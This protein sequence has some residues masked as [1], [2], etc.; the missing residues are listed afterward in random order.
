MILVTPQRFRFLRKL[1]LIILIIY[2]LAGSSLSVEVQSSSNLQP[3]THNRLITKAQFIST[4][5][6]WIISGNRLLL[7]VDGANTFTDITP[8]NFGSKPLKAVKFINQVYGLV[9]SVATNPDGAGQ[10]Q[11]A[12]TAD[13]GKNWN[14]YP[15]GQPSG[16]YA[17]A[18]AGNGWFSFTDPKNGW[19]LVQL[20]SS[21]NF[22]LGVLYNTN[23]GGITWQKLPA[24][25]IADKFNFASATNGWLAGGTSGN[26]LYVTRDA[27]ISWQAVKISAPPGAVD[28][29]L[30]L[31]IPIFINSLEGFLAITL[32]NK[33]S[34]QVGY[35][36]T[37]DGGQT[38]KFGEAAF[39]ANLLFEGDHSQLAILDS[40]TLVTVPGG[41]ASEMTVF[42]VGK[43]LPPQKF[44]GNPFSIN[45]RISNL[46]FVGDGSAGW[47]VAQSGHCDLFKADCYQESRL[48]KLDWK[49][50]T[51]TDISFK[52][53]QA[54][55]LP[56][57][58]NTLTTAQAIDA[59]TPFSVS[60]LQDWWNNT[61]FRN[62]NIYY[63]GRNR[64]CAT[65][66]QATITASWVSQVFSQGWGLI[67]T[68]VGYQ[69][70]T[71]CPNN[72]NVGVGMSSDASTAYNQGVDEANQATT[73]LLGLGIGADTIIYYDIEAY[74]YTDSSCYNPVNSFLQGW[75]NQIKANGYRAGIY[76]SSYG[77]GALLWAGFATP[78]D[79]VWLASWYWNSG[80]GSYDPSVSVFGVAPIPDGYWAAHQ[81][82]RQ[83]AGDIYYGGYNHRV[84]MS[85]SDGPVAR[86]GV[87]NPT[88]LPPGSVTVKA[89]AVGFTRNNN[90]SYWWSYN[91]VA[92]EN[93]SDTMYYTTNSTTD[94]P[95]NWGKWTPSLSQA[96]TYEI[97]AS[98]GKN[99]N[100]T[101]ANYVISTSN[102]NVSKV[103]NQNAY[104]TASQYEWVS[105][106][107]FSCNIGNSCQVYLDD[108]V[109]EK[110]NL[111]A[112]IGFDSISWKLI[113]SPAPEG[114]INSAD[115]NSITGWAW[116]PKAPNV[117]IDVN[118]YFNGVPGVGQ[119]YITTANIYRSDVATLVSHDNGL[120]G[121]SF[122][123]PNVYK[124]GLTHEVRVYAIN[125]DPNGGNP[126]IGSSPKA[127]TCQPV[128]TGITVTPTNPN[129]TKGAT[130]QFTA[131]G[132]YSDNSTATV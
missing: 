59:C 19:L 77:S 96:G 90:A 51:T 50:Q 60:E 74:R 83:Y 39:T 73:A 49:T 56:P 36:H 78:P 111:Q 16:L 93:Y 118:V 57:V 63:G 24:P 45:E 32:I 41:K 34:S 132:T 113:A 18:F 130:Q 72:S 69:A 9:L 92:N 107:Q 28:G 131:I 88:P 31:D 10:L 68:W 64:G 55:G 6:G 13:S 43:S 17:D 122:A 27:G 53:P 128:L 99:A 125:T 7:T 76:G 124:D 54:L 89:N 105:L 42:K 65:A 101:G 52:I 87:R 3:S 98:I 109:P 94:T 38:W 70:P 1:M 112:K 97:Y 40:D 123:V 67:P 22:S 23:D 129:I 103:V 95:G 100:T 106:G 104:G 91:P 84:D 71:G 82:I 46:D 102:G 127:I 15:V 61:P 8:A 121:F 30:T 66:N 2:F 110:T 48:I 115:C 117:P 25:P 108:L 85:A 11:V 120:H 114:D 47:L 58:T 35:Y 14:Y 29:V 75:V 5:S 62:V 37:T 44:P 81:R 20:S 119:R 126:E 86:P 26:D 12:I 4:T 33:D 116:D 79:A 21:A 80:S